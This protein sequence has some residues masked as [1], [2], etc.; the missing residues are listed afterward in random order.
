MNYN[1]N[2]YVIPCCRTSVKGDE[3]EGVGA[4]DG[5]DGDNNNNSKG[6]LHKGA[7]INTPITATTITTSSSSSSSSSSI[8][9]N[10]LSNRL[11]V[12]LEEYLRRLEVGVYQWQ[13][14]D[15]T[16]PEM[17]HLSQVSHKQDHKTTL[18]THH[19][20]SISRHRGR[21]RALLLTYPTLA[22]VDLLT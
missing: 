7:L 17:M 13:P 3:G 11:F 14:L 2:K 10:R 19:C 12:W 18:F 8:V 5:N 21:I 1:G 22:T 20:Y 15:L 16:R 9:K 4:G 6:T